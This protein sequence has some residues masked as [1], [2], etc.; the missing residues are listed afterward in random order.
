[1][2][3]SDFST[4]E[5]REAVVRARDSQIQNNEGIVNTAACRWDNSFRFGSEKFPVIKLRPFTRLET[6]DP[7][8]D[9]QN[10]ACRVS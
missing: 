4:S 7:L 2:L 5:I 8:G 1:M 9:K 3:K 6:T 10:C